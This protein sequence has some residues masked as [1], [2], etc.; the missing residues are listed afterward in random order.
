MFPSWGNCKSGKFCYNIEDF[1]LNLINFHDYSRRGPMPTTLENLKKRK[2]FLLLLLA[3]VFLGMPGC[4]RSSKED[5]LREATEQVEEKNYRGAIV[6]LKNVLEKD[7]DDSQARYLL[8]DS[9]LQ[10]G[11]FEIA[12]KEFQ[13]VGKNPS[14]PELPLKMA[15]LYNRID[16]PRQA[17]E[18]ARKFLDV[19]PESMEARQLLGEAYVILNEL[20]QAEENYREALRLSPDKGPLVIG[21]A[22]TL[23]RKQKIEEA[24]TLLESLVLREPGNANAHFYLGRLETVRGNRDSAL[25]HYRRVNELDPENVPSLYT[26]GL[27]LLE[28]GELTE[29]ENLARHLQE[30]FPDLT[31]GYQLL[32]FVN[33]AKGDFEEAVAQLQKVA[34][35]NPDQLTS[36]MLGMSY[37]KLEQF[38]QAVNQFQR[39]LDL[40]PDAAQPRLILG[41]ILLRQERVDDAIDAIQRVLR[42]DGNNA[43]AHSTMGSAYLKKGL[44]DQ[45]V[46]EFDRA[47]ELD[48]KLLEA[49]YRKGLF[50]ESRGDLAEAEDDIMAALAIAPEVPDL[51]LLLA[52]NYL[53]QNKYSEAVRTLKEGLTGKE[54][55][56]V[57]YNFLAAA[58]FADKKPE[59]GVASLQKAKE[60]KP[61][62][63]TPYYNLAA[64]Y[65]LQRDYAR[66]GQEYQAIL[67]RKPDEFKAMLFLAL[68]SELK[69]EEKETDKWYRLAQQSGNPLGALA[70]ANYLQ[71]AGKANEA[72]A[73]LDELAAKDPRNPDACAIKGK[74]L[75]AAGQYERAIESFTL[76]DR[77]APGRGS[78]FLAEVYLRQGNAA[79]AG[80]I[81]RHLI[82][83]SPEMAAGYLALA[84][85]RE[86]EGKSAEAIN[87]LKGAIP[88]LADNIPLRMRLAGIYEEKGDTAAALDIYRRLLQEDENFYPAIYAIGAVH[89]KRGEKEQAIDFYRQTL[90]RNPD[91]PP[92]LNNLAYAYAESAGRQEEALEMALRAY[93]RQPE[94]PFILDTLG[95][96]F[97]RNGRIEDA[98][99][100]LEKAAAMLPDAPTVHY[101]LALAYERAGK[102]D[103]SLRALRRALDHG[104]F[105]E[106]AAARSLFEKIAEAKPTE[107]L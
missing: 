9:Y 79:K 104:S 95:Y 15:Q 82:D 103:Q 31:R 107:K 55:D 13:K 81:A 65:V 60:L 33:C 91:F 63:L 84:A 27:L 40:R 76:L 64:F 80:E 68:T 62:Y 12:E 34:E 72:V 94:N 74:I 75:L 67:A 26:T 73:V 35:V 19:R 92:A 101:H 1:K 30:K 42:A 86:K 96:V 77:I 5:F 98:C 24:Q 66:S 23:L 89:E 83:R 6:L 39:V 100:V 78:I 47:I 69:G 36:Y 49:H 58:Y 44:F 93:R 51:R 48:P 85:V 41:V 17:I 54:S 71:R 43:L 4:S 32:G 38:E 70:F 14:F 56:A 61:S 3:V 8:A 21:L 90:I 7:P 10:E 18:Q 28:K 2:P 11:K 105:P 37:Y 59:Q 25:R 46:A 57:I 88:Q 99:R 52:R 53:R 16:R 106:A 87:L 50:N 29:A 97:Y 45:A 102:Q 22:D 20:D